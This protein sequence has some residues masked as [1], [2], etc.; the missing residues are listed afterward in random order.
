MGNR[1]AE[2]GNTGSSAGPFEIDLAIDRRSQP[3]QRFEEAFLAVTVE[4]GKPDDLAGADELRN[5]PGVP[6]DDEC[7]GFERQSLRHG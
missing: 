4:A 5:R 3:R 7:P 2:A 6:L 1:L